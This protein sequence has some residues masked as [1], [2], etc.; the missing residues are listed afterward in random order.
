MRM[1]RRATASISVCV[2]HSKSASFHSIRAASSCRSPSIGP[3]LRRAAHEIAK[4]IEPGVTIITM[5]CD[6][7]LYAIR[8]GD[9]ILFWLGG[10][11]LGIIVQCK[12]CLSETTKKFS[13]EVA[14]HFPGLAGLNKPIVWVFPDVL[15]CLQCGSAAFDIPPREL[16]VLSAGRTVEGAAVSGK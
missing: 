11:K 9:E 10:G 8:V 13:A 15:V 2:G 12:H 6:C 5:L 4:R 14:I 7:R 3:I 1:M 16:A